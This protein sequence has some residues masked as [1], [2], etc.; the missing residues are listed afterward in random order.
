LRKSRRDACGSPDDVMRSPYSVRGWV[1]RARPSSTGAQNRIVVAGEEV[2]Q[3]PPP[4]R[5]TGPRQR[6]AGSTRW[7]ENAQPTPPQ[8]GRAMGLRREKQATRI[9]IFL[10]TL[11]GFPDEQGPKN[12][13]PR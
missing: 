4:P 12:R 13:A 3:A 9:L 6:P 10:H 1:G 5:R 8:I 7:G 2:V 11:P